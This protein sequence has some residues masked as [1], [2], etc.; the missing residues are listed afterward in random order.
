MQRQTEWEDRLIGRIKAMQGEGESVTDF[1]ERMGLPLSQTY[2]ILAGERGIGPATLERLRL[3]QP[4]LVAEVFTPADYILVER[5]PC[6]PAA[7]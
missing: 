5:D 6:I 3:S 7:G 2:R 4:E 1:A